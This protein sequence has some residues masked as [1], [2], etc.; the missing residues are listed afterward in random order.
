MTKPLDL[1]KLTQRK[2]TMPAILIVGLVVLGF[3]ANKLTVAYLSD[4][5]ITKAYAEEEYEQIK[6]QVAA[7]AT[8]ITS[9]IKTYEL[10]ENAKETRRISDA[11]YDLELYVAANGENQLTM[12]R[13]RDLAA[14]LARLGRQRACIVRNDPDEDCSATI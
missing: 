8:L 14:E 4:F 10:N 5:F 12:T 13:K 1:E 3:N 11:L 6:T 7:N 9:H 2:V